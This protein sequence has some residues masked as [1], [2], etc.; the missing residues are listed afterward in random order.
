ML[1]KTLLI[2]KPNAIS[3]I[4]SILK[5]IEDNQFSIIKIKMFLMTEEF[6]EEFYKIHNEKPFFKNLI[7]FMTSDK[8]LA[9]ELL[10]ENAIKSLREVI[11][12]TDNTKAKN[13]T[14]RKLYGKNITENA[15]HASDS[16]P[17]A[18]KEIAFIFS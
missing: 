1:E 13:G 8:I 3:K 9:V 5:I 6:A 18:D 14:I 7:T 2:I 11:G 4:G 10:K 12:N 17:N 16:I 15:V